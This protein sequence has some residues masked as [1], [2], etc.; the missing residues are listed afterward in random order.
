[1]RKILGI[2][3]LLLGVAFLHS[4]KKDDE[5]PVEELRDYATQYAEDIQSIE[6]YLQTHYIESITHNPG[7]PNDMDVKLTAIPSGGTQTSI[8]NQTDYPLQYITVAHHDITYKIYYIMTQTGTGPESKSPCNYDSVLTAYTG[9]LLDGTVFEQNNYPSSY[10]N[11]AQVIRG[12]SEFFPKMRTGSYVSNP[13]GTVSYAN[14]GAAVFFIP[15]GLAYYNNATGDVPKY[16]PLIFNVK[17]YEISRVDN[18]LDGIYSFQ[19]DING[20]GYLRDNDD[21]HE[22]DTDQDGTPDFLDVDD[23]GDYFNTKTELKN[24]S[25]YYT[26]DNVPDCSGDV[27]TPTRLRKY[28]NASCH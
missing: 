8:W 3:T 18:D 6:T 21:T 12:W 22:D 4:C 26:F 27:T 11:L 17:L 15:S 23:D 20:D 7:Q 28:R 10:L 1:M 5:T 24:G 2:F 9:Q 14:F 25:V 13:D 19:E 16:A